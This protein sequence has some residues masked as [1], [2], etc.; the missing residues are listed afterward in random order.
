[1]PTD[2]PGPPGSLLP[3]WI[4]RSVWLLTGRRARRPAEE[5]CPEPGRPA[6]PRESVAGVPGV[7]DQQSGKSGLS[8]TRDGG[9]KDLRVRRDGARES[10][11]GTQPQRTAPRPTP[12]GASAGPCC[13]QRPPLLGAPSN[14]KR[15]Y[16]GRVEVRA[17]G[18]RTH[19]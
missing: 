11:A 4:Q 17:A 8:E 3:A 18:W 9:R 5:S 16:W 15:A 10:V 6:R 2:P 14:L 19:C 12:T 13:S 7:P 1:M